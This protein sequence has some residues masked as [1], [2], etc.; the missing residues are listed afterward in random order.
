MINPIKLPPSAFIHY[1]DGDLYPP[2]LHELDEYTV[3][4]D[5]TAVFEQPMPDH[6]IHAEINLPQG[7]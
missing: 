1:S 7:E 2:N 3:H 6:L 5:G 4:P